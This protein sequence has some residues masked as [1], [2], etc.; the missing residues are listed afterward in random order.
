M[1][2]VYF[3]VLLLQIVKYVPPPHYVNLVHPTI[4]YQQLQLHVILFVLFQDVLLVH[5]PQQLHVVLV[6]QDIHHI[7]VDKILY[8]LKIVVQ[9]SLI[10]EMEPLIVRFVA[11]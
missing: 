10:L 7:L 3:H 8:V 2:L 4:N 1:V 11:Y 9:D 6:P 5:L